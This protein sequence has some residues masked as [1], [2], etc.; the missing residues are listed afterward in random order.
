M[1]ERKRERERVEERV[2]MNEKRRE[3]EKG[4]DKRAKNEHDD[5]NGGII[6]DTTVE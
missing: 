1:Y 5:L 4:G 3:T 2:R 6:L